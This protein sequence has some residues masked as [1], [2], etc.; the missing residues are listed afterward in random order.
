MDKGHISTSILDIKMYIHYFLMPT[1]YTIMQFINS[2]KKN[3]NTFITI[4][5]FIT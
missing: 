1:I 4:F 5:S 3:A 2:I